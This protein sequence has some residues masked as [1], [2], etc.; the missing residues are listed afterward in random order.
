MD[1]ISCTEKRDSCKLLPFF[2]FFPKIAATRRIWLFWL[3][4]KQAKLYPR[5][6][7]IRK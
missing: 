5:K 3:K 2:V 6:C 7:L 1:M 4:C